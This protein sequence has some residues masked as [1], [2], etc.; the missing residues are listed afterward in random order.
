MN[1]DI[2]EGTPLKIWS[3]LGDYNGNATDGIIWDSGCNP[4]TDSGTSVWA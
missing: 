2:A 4:N 3:C 1:L